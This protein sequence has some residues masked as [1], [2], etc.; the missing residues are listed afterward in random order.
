METAKIPFTVHARVEIL[1]T[2]E[3]FTDIFIIIVEEQGTTSVTMMATVQTVR[4]KM[5]QKSVRT[6]C[7]N[8][9]IH[10]G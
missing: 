8:V 4:V 1:T 10:M 6:T 2:D 5:K 7:V 9:S 3:C